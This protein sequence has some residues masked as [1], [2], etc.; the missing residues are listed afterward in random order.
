MAGNDSEID[1]DLGFTFLITK[2]G[3]VM[4]YHHGKLATRLNGKKASQFECQMKTCTFSE[5]QQLMAR[6]T[7]NYKHGNE[8][9][10]K[11]KRSS[12]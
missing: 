9:I 4:V 12:K 10:A 2:Q 7:G 3:L 6:V 5:Q 11:N 8:K 1:E